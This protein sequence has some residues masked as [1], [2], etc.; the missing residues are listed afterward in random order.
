MAFFAILFIVI[1]IGVVL[2]L[3]ER[4]EKVDSK[5]AEKIA[6]REDQHVENLNY[7]RENLSTMDEDTYHM[8][9]E[10]LVKLHKKVEELERTYK[11]D[12]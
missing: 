2:Y 5:E 4:V 10:A 12:H 7:L 11:R 3:L 6:T 9:V 1:F 8:V